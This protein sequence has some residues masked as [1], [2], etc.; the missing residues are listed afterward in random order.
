M[1]ALLQK[2]Q[3]YLLLSDF[4][5]TH[6]VEGWEETLYRGLQDDPHT[7]HIKLF[8]V[9]I[10]IIQQ[11]VMLISVPFGM[12]QSTRFFPQEMKCVYQNLEHKD[13]R[14]T[15]KSVKSSNND[16]ANMRISVRGF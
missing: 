8:D 11:N 13:R 15:T 9:D 1:I 3:Y 7:T 4:G 12:C 10:E 6:L 14:E 2:R 5:V 16:F